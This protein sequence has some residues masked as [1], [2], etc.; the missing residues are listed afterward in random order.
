MEVWLNPILGG[1]L[2]GAS[3]G[4]LLL[5]L[6]RVAGISGIYWRMF[7]SLLKPSQCSLEKLWLPVFL[8]GMLLGAYLAHN[9]FDIAV[10]SAPKGGTVL[11]L[12]AGLLVGFGTRLGNGCTSGHGICGLANFSRRSLLSVCTFM[13]AGFCTVFIVRHMI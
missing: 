1:M 2:I 8:G 9:V 5:L 7:E 6:G 10:P 12:V 11:M 13:L 3:A 4:L